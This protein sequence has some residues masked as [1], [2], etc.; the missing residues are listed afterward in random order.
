MLWPHSRRCAPFLCSTAYTLDAAAWFLPPNARRLGSIHPHA[1]L[2]C[3][4]RSHRPRRSFS[5]ANP[6]I[7][8][9]CHRWH[10]FLPPLFVLAHKTCT[11]FFLIVSGIP[12]S[13]RRTIEWCLLSPVGRV[14]PHSTN[15]CGSSLRSC[16]S[17]SVSGKS[18]SN[19]I[20]VDRLFKLPLP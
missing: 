1:P 3:T 10:S 6:A 8:F 4:E 19:E 18:V 9:S 11:H 17:G 2:T 16:C 13:P 12:T 5:P 7:I 15:P 20:P 14:G